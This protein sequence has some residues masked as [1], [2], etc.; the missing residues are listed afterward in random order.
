[1]I[2]VAATVYCCG[3]ETCTLPQIELRLISGIGTRLVLAEDC[4]VIS[5]LWRV[6][7][8]IIVAHKIFTP[9]LNPLRYYL[10]RNPHP[11][12]HRTGWY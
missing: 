7:L 11:P 2:L 9:L 3:I 10:M 12:L 4:L 6:Y 5:L 1:M 8:M